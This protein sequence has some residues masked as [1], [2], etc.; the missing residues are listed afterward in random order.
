MNEEVAQVELFSCDDDRFQKMASY[1]V[2]IL[3]K[4][5]AYN[6]QFWDLRYQA[7]KN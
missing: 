2:E 5:L 7:Q 3:T 6:K 1:I 4:E